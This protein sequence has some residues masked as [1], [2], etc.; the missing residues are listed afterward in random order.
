MSKKPSVQSKPRKK[1]AKN[2]QPPGEPKKAPGKPK[3]SAKPFLI[4][5]VGASAGG[6]QAFTAMLRSLRADA[7]M[8]LVFICH[9]DPHFKS[10]LDAIFQR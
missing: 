1:S 10:E 4:V 8:A 5:G 9:Q 7:P 3:T 6:M 2:P